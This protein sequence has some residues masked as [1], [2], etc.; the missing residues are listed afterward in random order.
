VRARCSCLSDIRGASNAASAVVIGIEVIKPIEPINEA[1][2]SSATASLF[3]ASVNGVPP[4]E[5]ISSTGS[6]APA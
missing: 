6:A 3:S 2:I 1:T 5:K 4:I